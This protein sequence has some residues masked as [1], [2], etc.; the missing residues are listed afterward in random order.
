LRFNTLLLQY[1]KSSF[2][3]LSSVFVGIGQY[4]HLPVL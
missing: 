2:S 3:T 4:D 1:A